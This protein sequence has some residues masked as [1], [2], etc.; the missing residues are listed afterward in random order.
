MLFAEQTKLIDVPSDVALDEESTHARFNCSATSDSSTPVTLSWWKDGQRLYPDEDQRLTL[1]ESG[2]LFIDFQDMTLEQINE[3]YV[4]MYE[5]QATNGYEP[6]AKA[7]AE[8]SISV[9]VVPGTSYGSFN[10]LLT[11]HDVKL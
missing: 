5:C 1:E 9:E 11:I 8:L 7:P 2:S 10:L 4:G 3:K 6:I